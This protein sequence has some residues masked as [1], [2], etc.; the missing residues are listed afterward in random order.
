M[1]RFMAFTAGATESRGA[2]EVGSVNL[3]KVRIEVVLA[4]Q[5]AELIAEPRLAVSIFIGRM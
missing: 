1:C 5:K 3:D 4:D 2:A